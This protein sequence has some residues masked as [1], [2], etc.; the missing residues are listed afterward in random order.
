MGQ[1]FFFFWRVYLETVEGTVV[2][3]AQVLVALA[4][5][6]EVSVLAQ[7]IGHVDRLNF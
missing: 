7:Q 5:R 2:L 1:M 4:H 6:E 3:D